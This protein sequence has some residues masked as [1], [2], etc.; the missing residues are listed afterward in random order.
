MMCPWSMHEDDVGAPDGRQAVGDDEARAVL[1]ELGHGLLDEHLGARVDRARGLVE[2]EDL[3]VGQERPGDGRGAASRPATRRSRRRRAPCR[4]RRAACAR[5]GRRGP[6]WPRPHDSSSVAP[7]RA[8]GDVVA[9][10]A[11]EQPGVLQHHAEQRAQVARASCR[12]RR[13]RR[14]GCGRGRSRRSAAAGSPGW[15]CRR[16]SGRRWPPS[17]RAARRGRGRRSAACRPGSGTRRPR[18]VMWPLVCSRTTGAAGSGS[19]SVSSSSSKTR[20]ADAA[21]LC[22]TFMMLATCVIG[23]RELARVLDEG[24]SRRRATACRWR[25]RGRRPRRSPRSSGC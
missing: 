20:S 15:S 13:R 9:D 5:S 19:S 14:S 17:G 25:P 6:P 3:G 7:S 18:S 22:S 11:G 2:D 1:H 12:A 10:R 16:R 4:S 24:L 8:V 23:M 21:V